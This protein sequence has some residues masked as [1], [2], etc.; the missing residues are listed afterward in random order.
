LTARR[1]S[2]R[3][4]AARQR[5]RAARTPRRTRGKRRLIAGLAL[6][7]SL[8]AIDAAAYGPEG[9]LIAGRAAEPLLCPRAAAEVARLGGGEDLGELGLW[10]DRIRS[11][12]DYADAAPWHYVNIPNGANIA[13]HVTPPEGDVLWAIGHFRARLGDDSLGDRERGE[14]LRFLA[15]FVVDLHQ[16]LHVGLAEDRGGNEIAIVYEGE[17]INLHGFWDTQVINVPAVSLTDYTSAVTRLAA[18]GIDG[19][20]ML[21]HAVWASE[22]LALRPV[23]YSFGPA[24][25]EVSAN[26]YS[27]ARDITLERLALAAARLARTLNSVFCQ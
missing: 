13:D 8:I 3:L 16:P 19:G 9:H 20:D 21:N 22:S 10:A 27:G 6:L 2:A 18:A 12:P 26:Y 7:V 25:R 1:G 23:V 14:A 5:W 17:T 11:D 24:G 4:A 15:H